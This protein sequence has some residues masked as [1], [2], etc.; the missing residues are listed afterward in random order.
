MHIFITSN[1]ILILCYTNFISP[2]VLFTAY[3]ILQLDISIST[4]KI[5]DMGFF[6]GGKMLI[7]FNPFFML[8]CT[9]FSQRGACLGIKQHF[10]FQ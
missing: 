2:E 7:D 1:E 3:F 9:P 6:C 5:S 4:C 10:L 8:I